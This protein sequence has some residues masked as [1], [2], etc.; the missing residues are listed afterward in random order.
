MLVNSIFLGLVLAARG[1]A[2]PVADG[3]GSSTLERRV[4]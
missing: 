4:E 3:A 2:A 1:L